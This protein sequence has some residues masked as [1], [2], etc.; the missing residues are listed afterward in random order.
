MKLEA[1]GAR[2]LLEQLAEAESDPGVQAVFRLAIN[3]LNPED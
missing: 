2:P 1:V 3:Q